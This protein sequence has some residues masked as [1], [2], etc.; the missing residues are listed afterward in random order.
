M[1]A[2][3][4]GRL[5]ASRRCR[6]SATRLGDLHCSACR[7]QVAADPVKVNFGAKWA[8]GLGP[9]F[10]AATLGRHGTLTNK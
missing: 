10:S 7:C 2:W 1:T 8:E 6:I 4:R 3:G 9:P 5:Q